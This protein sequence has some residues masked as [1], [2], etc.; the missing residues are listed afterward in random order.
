MDDTV[1]K[2]MESTLQRYY[3]KIEE[4]QS[5]RK[6]L[7]TVEK[8]ADDIRRIL[9]DVNQLIPSNGT[10]ANY[11]LIVAE[12]SGRVYDTTAQAYNEFSR[13]VE[14]FERELVTLLQKK[15]K[16][17]MQIMQLEASLEGIGFALNLLDPL[18]RTICEQYYGVKRKSN[19]QI[20]LSLNMDEKSI[21]Y[22]KKIINQKLSEYLKVRR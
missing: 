14:K 10:V 9:L 13:S 15:I 8:N 11:N 12:S 7:E 21:R 19:L 22:R 16:L 20:G 17:K 6:A 1:I 3:R 18:D 5:K 2:E 4:L